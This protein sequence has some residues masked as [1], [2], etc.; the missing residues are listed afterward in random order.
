ML[1]DGVCDWET[2][3]DRCLFDGGDCCLENKDTTF[4]SGNCTCFLSYDDTKLFKRY[5]ESEVVQLLE[6]EFNASVIVKVSD[7]WSQEVCSV[8]CMDHILK[9]IINA[10]TYSLDQRECQ[11]QWF[12]STP[13]LNQTLLISLDQNSDNQSSELM[14]YLQTSKIIPCCKTGKYLC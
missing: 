4:C 2:N 11:C 8:L 7:V 9:E 1:R 3:H 12:E 10:W 14:T 6:A 13:C 5:E